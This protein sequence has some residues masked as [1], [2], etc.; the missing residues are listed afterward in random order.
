MEMNRD[1]SIDIFKGLLVIGMVYA[2]VMQFF[3]N[4]HNYPVTG[5]LIDFFN[6]VTFSGFVFSFG[7]VSQL[8]YYRKPFNQVYKKMLVTALKTL[9]AFYISGLFFRLF[10]DGRTL[11][12]ELVL[13]ILILSDIPGW[14][15]FLVSFFFIML[16]G[17]IFFKPLLWVV[18]RKKW[19]WLICVLFL[20]TTFIPYELITFNQLGLIIGSTKFASFPVVQYFPFYLLGMYFSK[21]KIT[22]H[23]HVLWISFLLTFIFFAY[24]LIEDGLPSRFP[25]SI[26]WIIASPAFLYMYYL[27]SRYLNRM[28]TFINPLRFMGRY[29]LF[30]LLMSNIMIFAL[31]HSQPSLALSTVESFLFTTG[32]LLLIGYFL[33]L[34]K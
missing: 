10:I 2:H 24:L 12:W 27:L 28:H 18:E 16:I 21:R 14:S 11:D 22:F 34:A 19:F 15:E 32:L 9:I 23:W 1:H 3:S 17:L 20:G 26:L 13:P 33:K 8:A 29:V 30:Y 4:T 25:P 31:K 5:T 6:I 7:Y